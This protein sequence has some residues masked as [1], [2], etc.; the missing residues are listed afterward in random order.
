MPLDRRGVCDPILELTSLP[1]DPPAPA[2]LVT[3]LWFSSSLAISSHTLSTPSSPLHMPSRIVHPLSP[4]STSSHGFPPVH[5]HPLLPKPPPALHLHPSPEFI[6]AVDMILRTTQVSSQ[7]V[8][9][10]SMYID[11]FKKSNP[12]QGERGSELRLLVVA[13]LLANKSVRPRLC[14]AA[15][16]VA[17]TV[18]DSRGFVCRTLDDSAYTNKTWSEVSRIDLADLNRCERE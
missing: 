3:F 16:S 9:L 4:V 15:D 6:T 1:V 12:T 18:T 14:P 8:L 11:R 13:F 10:A 7:V 17:Q 5:H 2:E